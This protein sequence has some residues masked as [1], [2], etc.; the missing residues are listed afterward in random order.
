MDNEEDSFHRGRV[1]RT[2]FSI[3]SHDHPHVDKSNADMDTDV[4]KIEEDY[5]VSP[6][7]N[8]PLILEMA[9]RPNGEDATNVGWPSVDII[10]YYMDIEGEDLC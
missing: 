4:I 5:V 3:P 6:L 8:Q 10:N 9:T 1:H 7:Q 2:G